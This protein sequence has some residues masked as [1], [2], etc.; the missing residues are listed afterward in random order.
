MASSRT[1]TWTWAAVVL[2]VCVAAAVFVTQRREPS[3]PLQAPA[4][5]APTSTPLPRGASAPMPNLASG[6]D[7]NTASLSQLK[8]LP[9]MT[10]DYAAKIIAGRPFHDRSELVRAGIPQEVFNRMSPPAYLKFD[11]PGGIP[12]R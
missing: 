9:G 10:D 11:L 2:L 6:V 12:P 1:A 5:P 4:L 8:T 3:Q 7:L